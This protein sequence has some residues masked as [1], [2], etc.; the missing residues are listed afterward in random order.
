MGRTERLREHSGSKRAG[1]LCKGDGKNCPAKQGRDLDSRATLR[2]WL[3]M[4]RWAMAPMLQKDG[5][6]SGKKDTGW[7]WCVGVFNDF[8]LG[9]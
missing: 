5:V 6:R 2:A 7:T 3:K 9:I 1:G 8:G 4:Q